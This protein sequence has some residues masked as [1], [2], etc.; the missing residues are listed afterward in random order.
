MNATNRYIQQAERLNMEP[1]DVLVTL[2]MVRDDP[3]LRPQTTHEFT[4][5]LE[6]IQYFTQK[7][8]LVPA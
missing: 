7:E 4:Q 2:R 3:A 8:A 1:N 6:A 5:L